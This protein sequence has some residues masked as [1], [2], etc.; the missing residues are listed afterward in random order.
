MIRRFDAVV[1]SSDVANDMFTALTFIQE[2]LPQQ[3]FAMNGGGAN[4]A[5]IE[6]NAVGVLADG[7][8]NLKLEVE[9]RAGN[10]S[11]DFLLEIVI[12]T[13]AP[14]VSF[15]LPAAADDEDGLAA[16]SDTGNIGD[17]ASFADRITSDT[18]PRL[19]GRA[20]ADTIVRVYL[21]R[22]ADGI[23]DLAS[24]TFLGQTVALPFDGNDAYPDGYWELTTALDLNEIV[25]LPRDGLRELLVTAED[26]AGNPMP[27]APPGSNFLEIEEN[28]DLLQIFIDTQGPQVDDVLIQGFDYDLFDPKPSI[29][30]PTPLVH[31]LE[32]HFVDQPDRAADDF[33]YNALFNGTTEQSGIFQLSGDHVGN[34]AIDRIFV[35]AGCARRRPAGDRQGDVELCTAVA[36][37]PLHAAGCR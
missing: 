16:D 1:D 11:H 26:V 17:P 19:W 14:P 10:I 32:V 3:F 13:V 23:I 12:D 29:N 34:I 8:H 20:E 2:V 24:D 31:A 5:V 33:L 35:N 37:R 30:G 18:T 28:V 27:M 9:D 4:A 21:D 25:G 15:G 22:D 36:R 6:E 7:V